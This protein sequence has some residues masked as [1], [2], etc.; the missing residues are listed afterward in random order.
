DPDRD[1]FLEYARRS[2]TGLVSH[3][4]KD[5]SDAIMHKDGA[6]AEGPIA[7]CEV[8]GYAYAARRAAAFVARAL[9]DEARAERLEN[10]ATELRAAFDRV[11]WSDELDSYVLALD[12]DKRPC[13]VR[14]SNAGHTLFSGIAPAA[15]AER[16]CATLMGPNMFSG[17]GIRT[18]D[19]R[20]ARYN[21]MSYHNGSVWPH[22]NAIAA[23]GMA[24]YGYKQHA[25][26]VFDAMYRASVHFDL[27]RMPELFCGFTRAEHDG[28][29]PYP[30]AC[31]PQAWAAGA[32]FLLLQACIGLDIDAPSGRLRFLRP[33]LPENLHRLRIRNLR[34]GDASA[35]VTV[36]RDGPHVGIQIDRCD[37]DLEIVVVKRDPRPG[38]I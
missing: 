16:L 37:G 30:V 35:D 7:L 33:M 13:M 8:Q 38:P 27:H 3:G 6:L 34:V 12:G 31:S 29:T 11:F 4:W 19:D 5:S 20:E 32:S 25:L 15:R 1:G 18:L 2:R 36:H 28:P 10:R 14:A 24:R 23:I 9:G 22:D 21:P 17:W 26:A